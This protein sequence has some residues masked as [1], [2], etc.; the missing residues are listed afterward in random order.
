MEIRIQK[1]ENV[2]I[3]S[4]IT[5]I[6]GRNDY[7]QIH[8]ALNDVLINYSKNII[9]DLKGV[10]LINS[11]G[12]GILMSSWTHIINAEGR[13]IVLCNSNS[14]LD[15]LS[16]CEIDRIIPIYGNMADAISKLKES[17]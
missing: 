4:I 5:Q 6:L 9:M 14:I 17:F 13:M 8:D 12:V 1:R 3:V 15:I 11:I 7:E 16:L 2:T 10:K